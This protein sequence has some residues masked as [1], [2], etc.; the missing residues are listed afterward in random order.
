MKGVL[1]VHST[2]SDGE[3]TL[4]QL[5][6]I[7]R[8]DGC[9]FVCVSDHADAF[10]AATLEAYLR[11]CEARSDDDFRFIPSLE[12]GCED[13]MHILGY[14]STVLIPST[15][16]ATVIRGI[17]QAGG[18]AVIAHPKET[19][20]ERITR[21]DPLPHGIEVWNTKYDG[22]YGPRPATFRLLASV[23][24]RDPSVRAFFGQDL[25]W[26]RQYRGMFVRVEAARPDRTLVLD[27]L[28]RG[29]YVGLKEDLVLLSSGGLT[30]A[31]EARFQRTQRRTQAVR[32]GF[33]RMKAWMDASGIGLPA[34][35]KAQIR[36]IF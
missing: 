31:L 1:H 25:H 10:D 5:R 4:A 13:R 15:D 7:F 22:R 28:R 34:A 6:D 27:A 24:E 30:P 16:P 19:A 9:R 33:R 36:R 2:W 17:R 18:L 8:A 35:L 11:E 32:R 3:F 23:R 20:F 29:A 21:F 14:G 26:R 12:Y